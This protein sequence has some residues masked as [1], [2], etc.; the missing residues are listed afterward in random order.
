M[1][2]SANRA[3]VPPAHQKPFPGPSGEG[4]FALGSDSRGKEVKLMAWQT[5]RRRTRPGPSPGTLAL[6]VGVSVV[7]L[8]AAALCKAW[9]L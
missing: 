2:A 3:R 9:P 1:C 6:V 8:V 7:A 5:P 4:F